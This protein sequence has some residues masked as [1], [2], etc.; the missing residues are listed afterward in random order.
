MGLSVEQLGVHLDAMSRV[1]SEKWLSGLEDR[2]RKELEFHD[3]YR[4]HTLK[5]QTQQDSDT[6]EKLYGNEKYYNTTR[7]SNEYVANWLKTHVPGKIF[8]DYACGDG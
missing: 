4:D 1:P 5:R 7:R 3:Q 8:L 6:F 2:K